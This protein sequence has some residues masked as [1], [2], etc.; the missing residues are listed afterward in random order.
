MV[1]KRGFT[2]I[3]LVLAV[4]ILALLGTIAAATHKTHA[5]KA[6]E[7]VLRHNLM[8]IRTVLD[9]YNND[10]GNYPPSLDTLTEEGY[11]REIPMDPITKSRESWEVEYETDYDDQDSNYE[12]GVF[13]V[14]SGSEDR[15]LDGTYYYEW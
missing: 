15:A 13:D 2:L 4:A 7:A 14:H 11:L 10:K 12:P 8:Q 9:Q 1:N 3:E 6:R 5:K